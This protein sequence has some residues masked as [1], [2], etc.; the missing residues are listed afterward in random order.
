MKWHINPNA[1]PKS[2]RVVPQSIMPIIW[3]STA[4]FY[5][6]E[7]DPNAA[8]IHGEKIVRLRFSL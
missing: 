2:A 8:A 6:K 1:F 5:V 3:D 7:A 4:T